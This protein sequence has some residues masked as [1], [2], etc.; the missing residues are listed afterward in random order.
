MAT[1]T[2]AQFSVAAEPGVT[3]DVA[4]VD[5][6]EL[7]DGGGREIQHVE[8]EI[9]DGTG[10]RTVPLPMWAYT[11][12]P[13][14]LRVTPGVES[15]LRLRPVWRD[16]DARTPG[17]WS[18]PK[19]VTPATGPAR[20]AL[21][22]NRDRGLAPAGMIFTAEGLGF[23]ALR[24]FHDL[25]YAWRFGDPGLHDRLDP[26]LPWGRDRDV[27]YGP[28]VAHAFERPGTYTVT[29]EA[30][31]GVT[32]ATASLTVEVVDPAAWF[33]GPL[34]ICV[35]N[36]GNFTGA[37]EGARLATSI[38]QAKQMGVGRDLRFLL[39][40][41]EV[42][43]EGEAFGGLDT[44]QIGAFGDGPPPVWAMD[45][46][47]GGRLLV[48]KV[49]REVAIWGLDFVGPYEAG[50]PH[51][52]IRPIDAI[53]LE[54]AAHKT[55]HN[56][57]I[58]GW[59]TGVRQLGTPDDLVLSNSR[60]TNWFNYGVQMRDGG[61]IGFAG[62]SIRQTPLAFNDARKFEKEPPFVSDHGPFRLAR[63]TGPVCFTL[64]D[65]ATFNSWHGT[66]SH[67]PALR[68]NS[69][70]RPGPWDL[71]IDRLRG[72]GHVLQLTSKESHP[73]RVM[74]DKVHYIYTISPALGSIFTIGGT[75]IRNVVFLLDDVPPEGKS[76]LRTMV[77]FD[78]VRGF[79]R[80]EP[81]ALYSCTIV[82][83]RSAGNARSREGRPRTF[84]PVSLRKGARHWPTVANLVTLAPNG[85]PDGTVADMPLD[86]TPRW[87]PLYLGRR[88]TDEN[89][90]RTQTEYANTEAVGILPA[91]LPGSPAIGDATEGPVA[92]DDF[93]GT[94][95]PDRPSRGAFEPRGG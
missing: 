85:I 53:S 58:T 55:V 50:R 77:G 71:V 88:V 69:G 56:C 32:V 16:G 23:G 87:A 89:G 27:G 59:A 24:P 36:T 38:R 6:L 42:F 91:P 20:L 92:L 65:L 13:R 1:F 68:W 40:R 66:Q 39:R 25:R 33:R 19:R 93:F 18:P 62:M 26:S 74:V 94:P 81:T 70:S 75:T 46:R 37:P 86:L 78:A 30:T 7:P 73:H 90:G 64:A 76:G 4:V 79:S 5:L 54:S 22:V 9:D 17:P 29:C 80:H 51:N 34:T 61:W 11:G 49:A 48:R 31:D 41:G 60:I 12:H 21:A 57:L 95:R 82:D 15:T 83:L 3:A 35:S 67:Q 45:A 43:A 2:D 44:L 84:V 8:A 14:R 52:T 10:P 72:E 28:V 47:Q 63:P